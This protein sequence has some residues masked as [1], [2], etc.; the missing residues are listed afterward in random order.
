M[1]YHAPFTLDLASSTMPK[2][3][4]PSSS[5]SSSSNADG[6]KEMN[7]DDGEKEDKETEVIARMRIRMPAHALT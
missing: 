2:T 7:P 1:L 3:R 6:S 4:E 5:S